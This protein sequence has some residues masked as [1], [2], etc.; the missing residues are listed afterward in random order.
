MPYKQECADLRTQLVRQNARVRCARQELEGLE[1]RLAI[2]ECLAKLERLAARLTDL[3]QRQESP[4]AD[5]DQ[6]HLA[7]CGKSISAALVSVGVYPD[8]R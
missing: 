2:Y 1:R 6:A 7:N 4:D 3:A 5:S 8:S